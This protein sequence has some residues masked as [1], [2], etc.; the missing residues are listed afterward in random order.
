M[1]FDVH[2]CCRINI[3]L[4]VLTHIVGRSSCRPLV[5]RLSM[6]NARIAALRAQAPLQLLATMTCATF[7]K[8]CVYGYNSPLIVRST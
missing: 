8:S 6:I 4:T 5:A 7:K 1:Q 2:V 3:A